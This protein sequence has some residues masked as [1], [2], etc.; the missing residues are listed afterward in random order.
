MTLPFPIS[1]Q[2]RVPGLETQVLRQTADD[3]AVT[4]LV[5]RAEADVPFDHGVR[6]HDRARPDLR[7]AADA[8]VGPDFHVFA[9]L[10]AGLDNCG[11]M[12]LHSTPI[13]LKLK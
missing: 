8:G 9:Q 7:L 5:L 4:N 12:N 11:R 3:R 6:L 2:L 13:S 1:T 10:R